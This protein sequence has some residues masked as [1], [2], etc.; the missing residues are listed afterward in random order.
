MKLAGKVSA[1]LARA[2][3]TIL[4]SSGWRSTSS[5][6]WA[7]SGSSSNDERQNPY[8]PTT[9]PGDATAPHDKDSELGAA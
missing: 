4:S 6:F 8:A 9:E 7:N 3:V 2:M 5:V 1:P